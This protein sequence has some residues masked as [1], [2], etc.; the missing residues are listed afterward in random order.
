M[1]PMTNERTPEQQAW[2][3]LDELRLNHEIWKTG[4]ALRERALEVASKTCGTS[5]TASVLISEA[6]E[7]EAY[8]NGPPKAPPNG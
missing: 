1:T 5:T 6:K 8:L 2:R 7:I 4:Y 3:E